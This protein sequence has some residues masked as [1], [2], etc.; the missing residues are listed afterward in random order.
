MNMQITQDSQHALINHPPNV[1]VEWLPNTPL[2][3]EETQLSGVQ[4][5]PLTPPD[6][7][8]APSRV[9]VFDLATKQTES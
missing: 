4:A 6:G 2:S 7:N 9:I 3:V 5:A 8:T 1:R